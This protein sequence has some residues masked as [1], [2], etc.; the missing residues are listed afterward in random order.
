ML[1]NVK[2]KITLEITTRPTEMGISNLSSMTEIEAMK[3]NYS[4]LTVPLYQ[5]DEEGYSQ[6]LFIAV[7]P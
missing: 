5:K 4:N 7:N 6:V 1:S 2:S 3:K